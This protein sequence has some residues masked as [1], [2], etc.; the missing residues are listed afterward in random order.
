[1]PRCLHT[2]RRVLA[3]RVYKRHHLSIGR[4]PVQVARGFGGLGSVLQLEGVAA[5]AEG[6]LRD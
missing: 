1:M 5:T 2:H 6:F 3:R 4:P